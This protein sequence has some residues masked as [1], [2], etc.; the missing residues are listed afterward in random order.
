VPTKIISDLA[1]N[2]SKIKTEN[3]LNINAGSFREAT[4]WKKNINPNE[5]L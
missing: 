4:L 1:Q 2:F 3:K 5:N